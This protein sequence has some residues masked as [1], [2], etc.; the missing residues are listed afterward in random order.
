MKSEPEFTH[1]ELRRYARHL[2][3]NEVGPIGQSKLKKSKVLVIGAGGLGTPVLLYLAAAGV[4]T[5]GIA[6]GDTVDISNLQRQ[7]IHS[8]AT[9]GTLKVYS[10]EKKLQTLNPEIT[11]I[12]FPKNI[13]PTNA[14][15]L[16]SGFDVIIDCSDNFETRYLANDCCTILDKPLVY[17]A[18]YKFEGQLGVFNFNGSPCYRCLYPSPPPVELAPDCGTAGVLGVLPGILGC[19][20]ASEAIKILLE[21]GIPL[22]AKI[23]NMDILDMTSR[24]IGYKHR[25]NCPACSV[26]SEIKRIEPWRYEIPQ[27][28]CKLPGIVRESIGAVELSR[29]IKGGEGNFELI[30]I[31]ENWEYQIGSLPNSKNI[32]L[33][34]L[35]HY[36]PNGRNA[37]IVLICKTGMRANKAYDTLS[38][39]GGG[40][41]V[42]KGGLSDWKKKVDRDFPI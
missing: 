28:A 41:L 33:N 27:N 10:A 6:D 15:E 16:V 19:M 25:P 42:L 26:N 24:K 21:I 4:G 8:T 3:L 7:V 39:I 32:P 14:L 40:V 5:L 30:D 23:W 2:S 37:H 11:V 1:A 29:S 9:V 36:R 18:I 13:D 38:E 12:P 17:A 34:E 31:R 35:K 22:S 20:Q